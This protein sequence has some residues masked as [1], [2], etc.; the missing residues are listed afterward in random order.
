MDVQLQGHDEEQRLAALR[1]YQVLDTP[2]EES[3]DAIVQLASSICQAPISLVTLIDDARQ[4]FKARVG[5]DLISTPRE[6]AF[7]AHAITGEELCLVPDA[8]ADERFRDNPM[9]LG[10]PWI[11]FYAGM[12]LITSDGFALGTL[13]VIDRKPRH[14]LTERERECLQLLA[15]ETMTQLE[16]RRAL[17]EL[18]DTKRAL[19]DANIELDA[20]GAAVAHDL[21]APVRHID[22]FIGLL[23][24]EC[25]DNLG[26]QQHISRIH[27]A[28]KN[29]Q[30]IIDALLRLSRVSHTDL[31]RQ[32]V[33]LSALAHEIIADLR[34]AEP[35]RKF[36]FIV[37]PN[38]EAHA[39][40]GLVRIVLENLLGNAAKFTRARPEARIEFGTSNHNSDASKNSSAGREYFVRD[41]GV[42]FDPTVSLV[43]PRPFAR[44]HSANNYE[45]IGIGLTIIERIIHRHDG[46]WRAEGRVDAGAT[47]TFTLGE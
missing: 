29:M 17:K 16:L 37:A 27:D 5:L 28:C 15:R 1:R 9:V 43:P 18:G 8:L 10:D 25:R 42:G 32:R 34:T 13:C 47:F 30:D 19:Q 33:D 24:E 35:H 21:R 39:D 31:K 45:G 6:I 3:F 14:D 40:P 11:R 44:R 12:P 4:W 38:V 22:G 36:E 20:F 23:A 26:A 7:C 46:K 2:P 41:N